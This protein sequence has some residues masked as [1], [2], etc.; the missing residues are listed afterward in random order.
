MTIDPLFPVNQACRI[1]RA[2]GSGALQ[3]IG[4]QVA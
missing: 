2:W 4:G 3:T 1:G